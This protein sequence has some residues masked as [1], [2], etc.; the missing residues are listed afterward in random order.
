MA[1]IYGHKWTSAYGDE[2]VD[3]WV[4]GLSDIEPKEIATGLEACV[5]R[6][7]DW[8]PSLPEFR[9][10]C[11][12]VKQSRINSGMYKVQPK[13]LPEPGDMKA[14]RKSKGLDKIQSIRN[15]MRGRS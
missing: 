4:R 12:P 7:D 8:P 9:G 15:K 5:M 1:E 13:A 6:G 3:S 10:L 14:E 2:P 11:R